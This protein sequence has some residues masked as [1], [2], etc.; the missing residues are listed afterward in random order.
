MEPFVANRPPRPRPL[1]LHE[2]VI[3]VAD[4]AALIR[5]LVT[6]LLQHGGYFVLSA[7]DGYEA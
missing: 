4:D 1:G 5:N 2:P 6:L 7:A 3:F